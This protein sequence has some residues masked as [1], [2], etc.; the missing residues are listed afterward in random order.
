[1]GAR[2]SR[3]GWRPDCGRAIEPG[4]R[5][6]HGA[7]A[8]DL[9]AQP[10]AEMTS[11]SPT[12]DRSAQRRFVSAHAGSLGGLIALRRG[13]AHLAGS[14]LLDPTTGEYNFSYIKQYLPDVPVV[15]VTL[16]RREQGLIVAKGNPKNIAS[17]KDLRGAAGGLV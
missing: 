13:E 15:V 2:A 1:M 3:P 10:L 9:L 17:L 14:H 12:P 6:D 11:D 5:C 7:G 8:L 16:L 4:R